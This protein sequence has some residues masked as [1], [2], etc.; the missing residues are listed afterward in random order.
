MRYFNYG[1]CCL[2]AWCVAFLPMPS[3]VAQ[4]A[5][6]VRFSVTTLGAAASETYMP[7]WMI[8]NRFDI[9]DDEQ[10][11]GLLKA[12][13]FVPWQKKGPFSYSAGLEVLAKARMSTSRVQQG[14][15][16]LRYGPLEI[17]GGLEETTIEHTSNSLGTGGLLTSGNARPLPRITGSFPEFVSVPY[18]HGYFEIK[19][20]VAHGW[21]GQQQSVKGALLHEKSIYARAGGKLPVNLYWG[22][23]DVAQ[24]G[25]V[26]RTE[27]QLPS[28]LRDFIRV[29]RA[30]S[31]ADTSLLGES[32]NKLGNH[33]GLLDMGSEIALKNIDIRVYTQVLFED[34]GGFSHFNRDRL[35]GVLFLSKKKSLISG[36]TYEFVG[37]KY[38]GGPGLSDPQPWDNGNY[39]YPYGG[40]DNYYNNYL[41]ES[42]WSYRGAII[43]TP[44]FTTDARADKYFGGYQENER[45]GV[46][47]YIINNRIIGHHIGI[48][49]YFGD[50]WKYRSLLTYTKN[51]GTYGGLNGGLYLWGSM[52]PAYTEEYLFEPALNQVYLMAEVQHFFSDALT[53]SGRLGLDAGDMSNTVAASLG[54]K[55]SGFVEAKKKPAK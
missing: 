4:V 17:K 20:H 18:T 11:D 31:S 36:F 37:T 55:W 13:A 50:R 19:G 53:F 27:G 46:D 49:G 21:F 51:W 24:W 29:V 45:F 47:F 10:A 48:E 52:D 12:G 15:V 42:G 25:G 39:G 16:K 32:V 28:S 35:A 41:Y 5:D 26:H 2:L 54:A 8:S 7:L 6:S 33:I 34:A 30:K 44:L 9:V 1:S 22:I 43:G 23:T 38:Q 40:R 3:A 14:F